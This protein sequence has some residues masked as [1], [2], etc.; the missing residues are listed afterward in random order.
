MSNECN[1]LAR[2]DDKLTGRKWKSKELATLTDTELVEKIADAHGRF[3]A[4]LKMS[5]EAAY[6]AGQFLTW[7][8][9][10]L[11]HGQWMPWVKMNLPHLT[12]RSVNGYMDVANNWKAIA[13]KAKRAG[14]LNL[15]QAL[16][17]CTED[18]VAK[19]KSKRKPKATTTTAESDNT[20]NPP[21]TNTL[22]PVSGL[23]LLS[24][25]TGVQTGDHSIQT[26]TPAAVLTP[27]AARLESRMMDADE[28]AKSITAAHPDRLADLMAEFGVTIPAEQ[29]P[30]V[31]RFLF[32]AGLS[33]E[34]V[35]ALV[36]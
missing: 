11:P 10:Q 7:K 30:G 21:A 13:R 32:F 27:E 8:K 3:V 1:T 2:I 6:E 25:T 12:H 22:A 20:I 35:E 33:N 18:R 15:R 24:E 26:G 31:V 5:L 14:R 9:K 36:N 17:E 16:D 23:R 19:A 28:K 29:V 4:G 34:A